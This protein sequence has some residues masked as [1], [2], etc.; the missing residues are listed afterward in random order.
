MPVAIEQAV[1]GPKAKENQSLLDK[2]LIAKR[3]EALAKISE[4][5]PSMVSILLADFGDSEV[6]EYFRKVAESWSISTASLPLHTPS[7]PRVVD[8][9]PLFLAAETAPDP[10]NAANFDLAFKKFGSWKGPFASRAG[11]ASEIDFWRRAGQRGD[12]KSTRLN[13]SH[14]QISYAVFC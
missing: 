13:S 12:R 1:L 5:S 14:S 6:T 7:V 2:E 4:N 3:I 10:S 8:T 9:F 11:T